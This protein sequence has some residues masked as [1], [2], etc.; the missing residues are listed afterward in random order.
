[1]APTGNQVK[2]DLDILQGV[3]GKLVTDYET[4]QSA[5]STLQ[6]EASTH[7]ASWSGEAK[8]KWNTAMEGV[9]FAWNSLNTVLDEIAKNI[10]TS[11]ANYGDTDS[12]NASAVANVPT[13]DITAALKR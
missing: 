10:N 12:A 5:I 9:N 4:L 11:G 6:N 13:T 1:M 8:N 3:A 7:S 2:A